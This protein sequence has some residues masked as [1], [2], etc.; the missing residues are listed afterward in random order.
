MQ[1]DLIL[2]SLINL[3]VNLLY[4]LVALF[5][6]VVALITIDRK[7]LKNI[8]IQ[9]ELKN[10]NIAVAIFASSIMLFVALII[11]FGFKG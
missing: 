6:A 7:L 3:S 4:T 11:S 2:A 1:W 5:I 10:K 8:D 9:E